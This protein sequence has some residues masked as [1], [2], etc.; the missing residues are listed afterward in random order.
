MAR[1]S[2]GSRRCSTPTA[3]RAVDVYAEPHADPSGQTELVKAFVLVGGWPGSGKTTLARPLATELGVA[4]L[5]K[6]EVKETLMDRLGAPVTVEQSREVGVAAVAAVLRVARG[7]PAAVIDS[8]W[9]P[10]ARPMVLELPGPLV[11][12]RCRVDVELAR[13]RYHRRVRDARYLDGLRTEAELWGA[14]VAPLGVDPLIE[15]DTA[16]PVDV[17]ALAQVIRAT[18]E[19]GGRG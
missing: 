6:D 12:L 4:F 9:F 18:V 11:E 1:D 16:E 7:C 13:E 8:T 2:Q 19:R 3:S 17:V 14:E 5:S 15:V 10:Y